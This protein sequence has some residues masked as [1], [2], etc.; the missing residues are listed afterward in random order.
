MWLIPFQLQRHFVCAALT[1]INKNDT[2]VN[3]N[4]ACQ[5]GG[6]RSTSASRMMWPRLGLLTLHSPIL[7]FIGSC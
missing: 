6:L 2:V 1:R 7:L 3:K 4:A 5:L